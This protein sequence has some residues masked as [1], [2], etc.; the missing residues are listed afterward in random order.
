M[1][2]LLANIITMCKNHNNEEIHNIYNFDK[3]K[4]FNT[5]KHRLLTEQYFNK[6][7]TVNNIIANNITKQVLSL[8]LIMY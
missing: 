7:Q 6:K 4:T 1:I 8:T 2:Q 3:S 5:K